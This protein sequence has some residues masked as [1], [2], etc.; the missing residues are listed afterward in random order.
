MKYFTK[1]TMATLL[2]VIMLSSVLTAQ[3]NMDNYITL[4]VENGEDIKLDLAANADNTPIKIVSGSK[5]YNIITDT[6]G[7]WFVDYTSGAEEMT[8]YGNVKRL[9]CSSNLAKITGLDASHNSIVEMLWTNSNQLTSLDVSNCVK[10]FV[11]YLIE[12]DSVAPKF[13]Y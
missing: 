9:D 2:G 1:L 11:L 12:Q 13:I 7:T 8:I 3:V 5:E 4:T 6:I 10:Y